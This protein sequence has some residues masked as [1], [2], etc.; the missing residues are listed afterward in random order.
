M[1]ETAERK[2]KKMIRGW[3]VPYCLLNYKKNIENNF[4]IFDVGEWDTSEVPKYH[5]TEF[6]TR[7]QLEAAV[8]IYSKLLEGEKI[9]SSQLVDMKMRS[10]VRY[11]LANQMVDNFPE[12]FLKDNGLFFVDLNIKKEREKYCLK[13]DLIYTPWSREDEL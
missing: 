10:R 11:R 1:D 9:F 6:K 8:L 2:G 5:K 4:W 3:V 7:E 12:V 13:K